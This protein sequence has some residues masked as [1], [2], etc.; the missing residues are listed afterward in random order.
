MGRSCAG[1]STLS[2]STA[3]RGSSQP[4]PLASPPKCGTIVWQG[5]AMRGLLAAL[6]LL[7]LVIACRRGGAT[8]REALGDP[9]DDGRPTKLTSGTLTTLVD[10]EATDPA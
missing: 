8:S 6:F 5:G 10:T 2:G 9:L 1:C 4:L 3:R 7:I